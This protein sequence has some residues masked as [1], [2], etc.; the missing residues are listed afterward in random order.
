M[1]TT[2]QEEI[3]AIFFSCEETPGKRKIPYFFD[4]AEAPKKKSKKDVESPKKSS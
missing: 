2:K 4:E 1:P 3:T